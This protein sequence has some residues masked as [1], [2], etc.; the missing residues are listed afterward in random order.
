MSTGIPVLMYHALVAVPE[1][2]MA[3]VHVAGEAF[4]QQMAWLAAEGYQAITLLEL[5]QAVLLRRPL[6]EKAVALTFDDGYLSLIEQALPVLKPLGFMATLFLTTGAVGCP[7]YEQL[8][9]FGASAPRHDRPL[10]WEEVRELQRA[11]WAI[12]AHSCAHL[13]HAQLSDLELEQEIVGS[14]SQIEYQ[15]GTPVQFYAFPY[16]K[17]RAAALRSI[18]E[19]GYVAGF[20]VHPGLVRPGQDL[21]RLPRLEITAHTGLE[22]FQRKVTT[23]YGSTTEQ[24]RSK[25]RNLL[26]QSPRVK[27]F[28]Q[29]GF[30]K[31]IN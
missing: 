9:N 4:V 31:Y 17:Y 20:S 1:P 8:P 16:G 23:G 10:T 5:Q 7:S 27:D 12:E 13:N 2:Y 11:G 30:T 22:E 6:P 26:F 14:K 19:V 24:Y 29:K 3:P 18:Q 21:R 28:L 15:V 25:A